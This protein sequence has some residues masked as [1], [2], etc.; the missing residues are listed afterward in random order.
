[1]SS[2]RSQSI[3]TTCPPFA[4]AIKPPHP[5]THVHETALCTARKSNK[6]KGDICSSFIWLN[7]GKK[8][9]GR[10]GVFRD[11]GG[12]H[13]VAI[14]FTLDEGGGASMPRRGVPP[15]A[16][17]PRCS[18]AP[19]LPPPLLLLHHP[20]THGVRRLGPTIRS[21]GLSCC[22]PARKGRR[23]RRRCGSCDDAG[24]G[25]GRGC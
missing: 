18:R 10:A 20:G 11:W 23:P 19:P 13:S 1:M 16:L 24:T 15:R 17:V 21:P 2:R 12:L 25:C 8:K 4:S 9:G 22:C 3:I 6:G 7:A 5:T 14:H